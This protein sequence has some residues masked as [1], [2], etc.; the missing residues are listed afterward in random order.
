MCDLINSHIVPFL[1]LEAVPYNSSL[2]FIQ[3][4]H[5]NNQTNSCNIN[6]DWSSQQAFD[7]IS[8]VDSICYHQL[9]YLRTKFGH[10]LDRT[11]PDS[12]HLAAPNRN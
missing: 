1:H 6:V 9:E 10:Q 12:A 7:H 5:N 2:F 3:L 11:K 8:I 4:I